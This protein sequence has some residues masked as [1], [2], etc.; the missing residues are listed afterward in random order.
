MTRNLFALPLVGLLVSLVMN[1]NAQPTYGEK[2]G[3]EPGSRILIFHVD[4]A[5]M[6]YSSNLGAIEA[7]ER[8]VATS[9]S[10]MMPCPWVPHFAEYLK[11]NP[12]VDAGL[13]LTLNSEWTGYR[14]GPVAGGASVPGLMDAQG[15]LWNAVGG[16]LGNA[17][18]DEVEIE[19]RAQIELAEKLG[20]RP[21]HLDS[22]MGTLFMKPEF[23][24]KYLQIAVETKIPI[25][26]PGG[27]MSYAGAQIPA[28]AEQI[29][30]M[31]QAVW[32]SG[33]PVIDDIH[34]ASYGWKR[35]EKKERFLAFLDEVKPGI[36]EVIVHASRPSS[37]FPEITDSAE[38][39]LGDLE[40]LLAPEIKGKIEREGIVLTTWRELAR[41]RLEVN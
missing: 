15:Y 4:D 25:L 30:K 41:R 32:D 22:H 11:D 18:P 12:G 6:S 39:R 1:V 13:H 26:V 19:I 5:G 40:A 27:H 37:V 31:A 38:S 8:G 10:I 21:T 14:W 29:R 34:T 7:V 23:F 33:L 35:E 24:E 28:L 17:T 3:W 20:I 16:V 36:T 9:V 2:L